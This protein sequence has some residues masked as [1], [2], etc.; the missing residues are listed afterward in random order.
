MVV[1]FF[2][3]RRRWKDNKI[4]DASMSDSTMVVVTSTVMR[5]HPSLSDG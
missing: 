5:C 1:K 3:I 2:P 4:R